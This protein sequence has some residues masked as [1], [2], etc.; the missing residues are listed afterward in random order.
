MTKIQKWSDLVKYINRALGKR[1]NV[2]VGNDTI[3]ACSP[4]IPA[5]VEARME[6][7]T[8]SKPDF[9]VWYKGVPVAQGDDLQQCLRTL[10]HRVSSEA[11]LVKSV[12]QMI[13]H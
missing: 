12:V 5:I 6:W 9:L 8:I 11:K 4:V 1:W 2:A 7:S 13:R 10:V 3:R